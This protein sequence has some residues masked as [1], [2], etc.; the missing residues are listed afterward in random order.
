VHGSPARTDDAAAHVSNGYENIAA[1]LEP[2][3]SAFNAAS[4]D[5]RAL[6]LVGP[7]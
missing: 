6:L 2:L 5:A 7:T 4:A 1:K 3:R